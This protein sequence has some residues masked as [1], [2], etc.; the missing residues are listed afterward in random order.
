MPETEPR[1]ET[2]Q[3]LGFCLS[4]LP[5]LLQFFMI[6]SR[7]FGVRVGGGAE[8]AMLRG[9]SWF[10]AQKS[11]LTVLRGPYRL[12]EMEATSATCKASVLPAVLSF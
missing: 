7:Y 4:F 5:F 10:G 6:P 8:L 9:Y 1:T 11:L 3:S 2:V 12:L